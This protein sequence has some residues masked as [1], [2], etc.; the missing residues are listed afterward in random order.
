MTFEYLTPS[1]QKVIDYVLLNIAGEDA[2][3]YLTGDTPT[4]SVKNLFYI[5]I[6]GATASLG[7][8]AYDRISVVRFDLQTFRIFWN[9]SRSSVIS[10]RDFNYQNFTLG[11]VNTIP[12]LGQDVFVRQFNDV[13]LMT[14]IFDQ[15]LHLARSDD[16]T[17]WEFV[18]TVSSSTRLSLRQAEFNLTRRANGFDIQ[19]VEAKDLRTQV[20]TDNLASSSMSLVGRSLGELI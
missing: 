3:L 4:S 7:S 18:Q 10:Y 20:I 15:N 19:I 1:S 12:L 13:Y 5:S 9:T 16:A 6:T 17:N 2:Y 11:P 8:N 14:Y